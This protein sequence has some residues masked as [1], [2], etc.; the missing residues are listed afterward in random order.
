MRYTRYDL[1]G[2]GKGNFVIWLVVIMLLGTLLGIGIYKILISSNFFGINSEDNNSIIDKKQSDYNIYVIQ[3]GVYKNRENADMQLKSL[4]DDSRPFI[5]Q[6]EDKFKVMSG[7]YESGN[8]DENVKK[9]N[10]KI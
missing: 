10:Q 1:K 5:V 8:L 6:E 9:L 2:N 3:C 7:I 4:E